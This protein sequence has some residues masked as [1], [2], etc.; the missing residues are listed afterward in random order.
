MFNTLRLA[1]EAKQ[2]N[3]ILRARFYGGNWSLPTM[4]T[5]AVEAHDGLERTC[6]EHFIALLEART[7]LAAANAKLARMTGNLKRGQTKP[8]NP[9]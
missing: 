2:A 6:R 8:N 9:A 7:D 1:R 4:V 5:H 3:A